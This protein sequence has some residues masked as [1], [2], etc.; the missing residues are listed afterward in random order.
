MVVSLTAGTT[1]N[2]AIGL[3][4]L[5]GKAK[6]THVDAAWAGAIEIEQKIFPFT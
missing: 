6:W 4:E 1:T 2:G 3:I 5:I